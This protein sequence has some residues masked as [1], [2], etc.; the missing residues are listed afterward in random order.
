M[1]KNQ[2]FRVMM[3]IAFMLAVNFS[4]IAQTRTLER[5]PARTPATQPAATVTNTT[6]TVQPMTNTALGR[7]IDITKAATVSSKYI[8]FNR[9][10][11]DV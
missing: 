2:F 3:A 11:I 10:I 4:A 8:Y 6:P 7:G 1:K 5:Q 9:P